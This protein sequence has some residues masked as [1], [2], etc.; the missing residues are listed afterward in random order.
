MAPVDGTCD[1]VVVGGGPA[2]CAT[3]LALARG[4]RDVL[5][6]EA[7]LEPTGRLAGEW[8]HPAGVGILSGL[9]VDLTGAGHSPGRGFVTYPDDG[10]SPVVIPYPDGVQAQAAEHRLLVGALWSAARAHPRV[11]FAQQCRATH[12]EEGRVRYLDAATQTRRTA[13][14]PLIVGADGRASLVRHSLGLERTSTSLSRMAGFLIRDAALPYENYAHVLLG[15]PGP[16][17]LYRIAPGVV[18][19]CVDIPVPQVRH[20]ALA[21]YLSHHYTPV[22]PPG[23]RRGFEEAI[24]S[25]AAQWAANRTAARTAYGRDGLALVG[26]ATGHFHPLTASGLTLAFADAECLAR[27]ASVEDYAEN[28]TAATR[29]S[30]TLSTLL[31]EV[32]SGPGTGARTVRRSVYRLWRRSPAQCAA[33]LS[34]LAAEEHRMARLWWA[35]LRPLL[36]VIGGT[37]RDLTVARTPEEFRRLAT[38]VAES[39]ALLRWLATA[40]RHRSASALPVWPS[41]STE[42]RFPA[43]ARPPC[44]ASAGTRPLHDETT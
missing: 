21:A 3:A 15:G 36:D 25:G 5:V 14:A 43:G 33:T 18:R 2:G 11:A 9:G 42:H 20:R 13:H 6:L 23:L 41:A 4:G 38:A 10:S 8:I 44:S 26:D 37:V 29:T 32:L 19:V 22:F 40:T 28:R 39:M 27:A 16:V 24:R 31:Y 35:V 34:L 12:V 1:A 17:M 30:E 7:A